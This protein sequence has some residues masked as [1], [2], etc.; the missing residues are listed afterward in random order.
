[1]FSTVQAELAHVGPTGTGHLTED[2]PPV[3]MQ[4][5]QVLCELE[6]G[7]FFICALVVYFHVSNKNCVF[8]LLLLGYLEFGVT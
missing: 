7:G 6:G 4:C 1:M 3:E 2:L 8:W 5:Q